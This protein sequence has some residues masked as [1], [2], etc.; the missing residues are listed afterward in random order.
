MLPLTQQILV[1]QNH[2]MH[3]YQEVIFTWALGSSVCML[4]E[5]NTI[6]FTSEETCT[7]RMAVDAN[8]SHFHWVPH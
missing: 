5:C 6:G 7:Y 4:L 3:T 2:P 8:L 1:N